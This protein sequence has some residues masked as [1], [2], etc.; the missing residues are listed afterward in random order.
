MAS[1]IFTG[2]EFTEH[3]CYDLILINH[4]RNIDA[5][6]FARILR[7]VGVQTPIILVKEDS[8]SDLLEVEGGSLFG[9]LLQK[10]FSSTVLCEAMHFSLKRNIS[11]LSTKPHSHK[12]KRGDASTKK[13]TKINKNDMKKLI[14][15]YCGQ[16]TSSAPTFD[17]FPDTNT[18]PIMD[19]LPDINIDRLLQQGDFDMV[20]LS[21]CALLP[22]TM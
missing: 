7:K 19:P 18:F 2:L 12:V 6:K 16:T 14:D 5:V 1:N 15:S 21:N 8:S 22:S 20:Y 4:D 17:P 10:P 3:T 13:V 9:C 11:S